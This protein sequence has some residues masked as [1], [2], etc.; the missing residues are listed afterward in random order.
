MGRG[1]A[2]V[3]DRPFAYLS[4]FAWVGYEGKEM[5]RRKGRRERQRRHPGKP[6][7]DTKRGYL[8][9]SLKLSLQRH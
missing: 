8:D 9:Q 7:G 6:G 1:H 3:F 2:S 5:I 4:L